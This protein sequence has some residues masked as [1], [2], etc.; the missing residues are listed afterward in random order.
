M[1]LEYQNVGI[2]LSNYSL[3]TTP[4]DRVAAA[5]AQSVTAWPAGRDVTAD[6]YEQKPR[7]GLHEHRNSEI[8]NRFLL[9]VSFASVL[10]HLNG[11]KNRVANGV[12]EQ[13]SIWNFHFLFSCK[14]GQ[15]RD[16]PSLTKQSHHVTSAGH[17]SAVGPTTWAVTAN[18]PVTTR[19]DAANW[20][21][22]PAA[23]KTSDD[24]HDWL[25]APL[26]VSR[27]YSERFQLEGFGLFNFLKRIVKHFLHSETAW[28][29]AITFARLKIWLARWL[30]SLVAG[31]AVF[32]R[33]IGSCLFACPLQA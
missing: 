27:N 2:A 23:R 8:S 28:T 13:K 17:R 29:L 26:K 19:H 10:T 31:F 24:M 6:R 5:A 4:S 22:L 12:L 16:R 30:A 3:K 18:R 33:S 11:S 1:F 20:I 9:F 21:T 15:C 25:G 14:P 7:P 32:G